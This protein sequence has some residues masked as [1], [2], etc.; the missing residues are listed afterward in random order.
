MDYEPDILVAHVLIDVNQDENS[1]KEQAEQNI[2]PVRETIRRVD[3]RIEQYEDD[4]NQPR[5]EERE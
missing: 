3:L 5:E 1:R 2:R 4:K